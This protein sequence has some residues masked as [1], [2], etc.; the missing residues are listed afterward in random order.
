MTARFKRSETI[1]MYRCLRARRE[2]SKARYFCQLDGHE[3]S[4]E[5][6]KACDHR[7]VPNAE[8]QKRGRL[9]SARGTRRREEVAAALGISVSTLTAYELGTRNPRD[10]IKRALAKYYGMRIGELFFDE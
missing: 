4:M 6:C 3:I 8:A 9:I 5:I 2:P 7:S 1:D 10:N